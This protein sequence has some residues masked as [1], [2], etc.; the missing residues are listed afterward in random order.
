MPGLVRI[1]SGIEDACKEG[2]FVLDKCVVDERFYITP[3]EEINGVQI[4]GA[5]RPS[6]RTAP[7]DPPMLEVIVKA[8]TR[9]CTKVCWGPVM[10]KAKYVH[11][12]LE[13]HLRMQGVFRAVTLRTLVLLSGA[14]RDGPISWSPTMPAQIFTGNHC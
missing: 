3:Q 9:S 1:I 10:L 7:Y 12:H 13:V 11:E 4:R 6:N 14:V 2:F 5:C 8:L